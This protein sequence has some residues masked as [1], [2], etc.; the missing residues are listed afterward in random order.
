MVYFNFNDKIK[1]EYLYSFEKE[2]HKILFIYVKDFKNNMGIVK[3]LVW[4]NSNF[5]Y[6]MGCNLYKNM[7]RF[8]KLHGLQWIHF[9]LSYSNNSMQTFFSMLLIGILYI[10]IFYHSI[11]LCTKYL[12]L[13]YLYLYSKDSVVL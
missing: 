10:C 12:Y 2:S 8:V 9:S 7:T 4:E 5:F 6:V 3:T 1:L 13:L 11:Y